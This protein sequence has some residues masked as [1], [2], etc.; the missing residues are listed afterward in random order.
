M[1]PLVLS[2]LIICAIVAIIFTIVSFKKTLLNLYLKTIASTLFVLL[3]VAS[4][5]HTANELLIKEILNKS[6]VNELIGGF[7]ILT[8][9][10]FC[11]IGDIILGMPRISELK[12]DRLPVIIG[13]A[14]WFFIGHAIYCIALACLFKA[15]L[16]VIAIIIPLSLFYTFANKL[17]GKLDY[18]K[19]TVGVFLYS[20]V[21][22]LSLALCIC[23]LVASFSV[24]ALLLTI[25]FTLFYFSDMVLMHNYFGEKKRIVSILCHASYYPAQI[26]IALSIFFLALI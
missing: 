8:A 22:S 13:G 11:L 20:L 26:L 17:F 6:T 23:A 21:E 19:L 15:S 24:S 7:L 16:W 2:L 10:I 25:G 3:G 12:R 5:F 4:L 9:L 18:K 1:T 14:S